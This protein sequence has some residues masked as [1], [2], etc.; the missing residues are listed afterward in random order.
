MLPACFTN[1][2]LQDWRIFSEFL[3]CAAF[4]VAFDCS[5]PFFTASFVVT[6]AYRWLCVTLQLLMVPS[7]SVLPNKGSGTHT[8][9][10]SH[11]G[12]RD[13]VATFTRTR[14]I[15]CQTRRLSDLF[16]PARLF[17][18][19]FIEETLLMML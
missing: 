2:A 6:S 14:S 13:G 5:G 9:V 19:S 18:V 8:F 7:Y 16:P 1:R 12:D 3:F 17:G 15:K 10:G 4:N 11:F